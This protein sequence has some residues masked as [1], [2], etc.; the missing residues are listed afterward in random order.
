MFAIG[1]VKFKSL[2]CEERKMN[3]F[4]LRFG[5]GLMLAA[6]LGLAVISN[7]QEKKAT[8]PSIV[9]TWKFVSRKMPDG[10]TMT[11]PNC[12]GL[13]TFTK[14]MRNFNVCWVDPSGKHFSYSVISNY[15]LTDKDYTETVVYSCMN[16]EIGVMKDKP[17]GSGPQYVMTS[18]SKTVPATIEGSKISFQF[19]FDPP[20]AV[21]DGNTLTATLD[22]GFTDTWEKTR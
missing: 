20:K 18:Q 22:G 19:P 15:K 2:S 9:G 17:A 12:E 1:C 16:D 6:L 13:Q 3:R 14:T 10:T 11:P 5:V 21:F 8:A 7:A 4:T